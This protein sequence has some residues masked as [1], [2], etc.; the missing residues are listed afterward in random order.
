MG[1]ILA[2]LIIVLAQAVDPIRLL[3]TF[4]CIYFLPSKAWAI[5]AA[6]LISAVV[7]TLLT[8]LIAPFG[9]SSIIVVAGFAA[10]VLQAALFFWAIKKVRERRARGG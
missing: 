9:S 5:P 2:L 4:G 7:V 3:A 8:S 10:S 6:A 1:E